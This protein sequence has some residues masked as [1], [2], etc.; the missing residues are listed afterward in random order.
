MKV[1]EKKTKAEVPFDPVLFAA[2]V[3]SRM[4]TPKDLADSKER[5][6]DAIEPQTYETMEDMVKDLLSSAAPG[7]SNANSSP[8]RLRSGKL[9]AR[10]SLCSAE[11]GDIRRC[12]ATSSKVSP[13]MVTKSLIFTSQIAIASCS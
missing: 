5:K 10:S 3:P 7:V 11:I 13:G 4:P 6:D 8:S 12:I 2:T 1:K 9:L